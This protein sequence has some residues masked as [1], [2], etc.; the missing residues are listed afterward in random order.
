M[1]RASTVMPAGTFEI[2]NDLA[3]A[4]LNFDERY[5]RR[6]LLRDTKG[7][8]LLDLERPLLLKDG[9][10]L[11]LD[12]GGIILVKAADEKVAD[13]HTHSPAETARIAWH[14]GNRHIPVQVLADGSLRIRHDPVLVEMVEGLGAHVHVKKAPFAPE[15]GA[16]AQKGGHGHDHGHH[17]HE[18]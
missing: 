4:E 18:H 17:H 7:E 10:G 12:D 8:F 5:R 11:K 1:R 9:D 3:V 16:Y 14:I 13:I 15:A 2:G 6:V